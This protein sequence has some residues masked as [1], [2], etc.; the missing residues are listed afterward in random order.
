M[1]PSA[2]K[3]AKRPAVKNTTWIACETT[4]TA[5]TLICSASDRGVRAG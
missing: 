1:I 2:R 3:N 5:T 4:I